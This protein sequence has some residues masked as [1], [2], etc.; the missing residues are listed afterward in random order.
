MVTAHESYK[1]ELRKLIEGMK[2]PLWLPV[3]F[4]GGLQYQGEEVVAYNQALG[5]LLAIIK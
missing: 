3:G 2:K 1:K 4:Q 5:D